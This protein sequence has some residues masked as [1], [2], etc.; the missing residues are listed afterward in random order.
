LMLCVLVIRRRDRLSEWWGGT[1]PVVWPALV[2]VPLVLFEPDLGTAVFLGG[3]SLL[4]L[5][6]GGW[7]WR[8]LAT[9]GTLAVLAVVSVAGMRGYQAERLRGFVAAWRDVEQAPYQLKQSLL[10]LGSGGPTGAGLG[11]GRQKLGFLPEAHTDFAF[12]VVGEELGLVGTLAVAGLWIAVYVVGLR[13]LRRLPRDGFAFLAGV[14]LLTQLVIQA[15]GN[16]A[17]VTG[18]VP[19]KGL[20]HPLLS[21]GGSSLVVSIVT[22]GLVISMSRSTPSTVIPLD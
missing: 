13:L 6:L 16:V 12:A 20:P 1:V 3:V 8:H 10:A 11:H 19:T 21:Y 5:F 7:P 9:A 18:L 17:V 14:V 4:V 22:L 2:A 15:M